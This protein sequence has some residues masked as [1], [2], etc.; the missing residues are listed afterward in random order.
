VF[1]FQVAG[2]RTPD[3]ERHI[4]LTSPAHKSTSVRRRKPLDAGLAFRNAFGYSPTVI[5]RAPGRLELLGNSADYNQGL[6][7]AV[8]ID[9][10]VWVAISPR[11]DGQIELASSAFRT[12]DKFWLTSFE[13]NPSAPWTAFM[14]GVLDRLRKHGVNFSGFNAC[15][16]S[17]IPRGS[18]LGSS[19]ALT[20][21]TALAVRELYPWRVTSTGVMRPP[22]RT[23]GKLPKLGTKEA[24]QVARFCQEAETEF[25]ST[26][27]NLLDPIVALRGKEF[28][29]VSV[30]FHHHSVEQIP[31]I[32]DVAFVVCETG[33]PRRSDARDHRELRQHCVSA[34]RTLRA[35]SLRS[36]EP[37]YLSLRRK[38]LTQREYDCAYHIV[39]E[40]QRVA[41]ADRALREGD[42]AQFG[43]YLLQSHDSC[44][45][46][47]GNSSRE[48]D[49]L[50]QLARAHPACL[51]A[52]LA[53]SGF[54]G[55]TVNLIKFS[56]LEDFTS[57]ISALYE[58]LTGRTIEPMFCR[59][60]NGAE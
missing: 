14:K 20:V 57:S 41:F 58:K 46:F 15:V 59:I 7:M 28:H 40:N 53:G 24:L 51:G 11:V 23:K 18:G 5:T 55:A 39:G 43:Q 8:A 48:L 30:D 29:V 33:V 19:S 52:R 3:S 36:V 6:A 42:I 45:D 13:F 44:R 34:A 47:F 4:P 17:D 56:Q 9:R 21:A 26:N 27:C 35:R 32:D 37:R 22:T 2:F 16:F 38:R 60:V 54:G 12:R 25:A 31:L 10:S 49:L 1:G 50:V